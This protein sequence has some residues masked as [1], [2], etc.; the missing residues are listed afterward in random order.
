MYGSRFY[1]VMKRFPT[2]SVALKSL[3]YITYSLYY[4]WQVIGLILYNIRAFEA[5]FLEKHTSYQST[6]IETFHHSDKLQLAWSMSQILNNALVILAVSKV[7]SFLGWSTILRLLIRLPGF[8]SLLSLFAMT[9]AGYGLVLSLGN[10]KM[11]I[12]L[13]MAFA[14][15]NGFQVVL[16]GLLNFT[17]VNHSRGEFPIKVF[18]FVKINIFLLVLS[19]FSTFVIG[20]V[21]FSLRVYGFD[22]NTG[23][24]DEFRALF[25]AVRKFTQILYCYRAFAFYWEKFFVD[26][27]N[28]LCHYDYLDEL[29]DSRAANNSNN[30]NNNNNDNDN[31]N[32][33][34]NNN[35]N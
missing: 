9:I 26:H 32:D 23:I 20:S 4:I 5:S 24:S 7:P 1:L 22:E 18:S 14:I 11:E 31:D 35:R 2:T 16:I 33:N 8:W 28:I 34:D 27:R 25:I 17:Q 3:V 10:S 15:D 30:N 21:Q 19:Y 6:H 29:Q 12:A 13:I